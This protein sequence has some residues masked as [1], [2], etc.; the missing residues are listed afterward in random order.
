[1]ERLTSQLGMPPRTRG[2][3]IPVSIRVGFGTPVLVIS[4]PNTGGKTVTLKTA[5]LLALMAQCGLHIPAAPGSTLPVFRRI[6]ADIGDDQSIAANL[7]T[8]SAHLANVVAM[9]RELQQP[10]LVMLDEVGA[11]TDPQEG[12][13]LGV[14]VVAHFRRRGALV[15]ATTHHGLLKNW[16]LQ[17]DGVTCASFGYDPA[18]YEPTYRLTLGAPGRSLALEIAERYGLPSDVISEARERLDR[19]D[20]DVEELLKQLEEQRAAAALE[21]TQLAE[22][23]QALEDQRARTEAVERELRAR[24]RELVDSFQRDLKKRAEEASRQASTAIRDVVT[25]LEAAKKTQPAAL[26]RTRGDLNATLRAVQADALREVAPEVAEPETISRVPATVGSR[27]RVKSLGGIT[28]VVMALEDGVAELAV[29]GKRLRV[30]RTEL[31]VVGGSASG[32]EVSVV[33]APRAAARESQKPD[34][35]M[36]EVAAELHLLG[37]TVDEAMPEVEQFL[38]EASLAGRREVRIIHGFGTG[39]LR[40]AVQ[41][42]L[43]GHPLVAS[44]RLGGAGEGGG[45]ATVVELKG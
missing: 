6:F 31:V 34:P 21:K 13:A 45:G 36:D 7:S 3:P 33:R 11:G 23:R 41:Q 42:L 20:A 14:A 22:Q 44:H 2:E 26:A 43:K 16:A 15:M 38:D 5:G 1:M 24:K 17:T 12:G 37:K 8:F 4:G 30:P 25:K 9:T 39:T 29:S 35:E 27:V 32:G 10:S 18:S 40:R 19:R 28:G